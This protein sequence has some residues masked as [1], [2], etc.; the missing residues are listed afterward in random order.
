MRL[1]FPLAALVVA[2]S[3]GLASVASAQAP[4]VG[5]G[6]CETFPFDQ[7]YSSTGF[8]AIDFD[9]GWLPGGSPLQIRAT[10][11]IGGASTVKLAGTGGVSY[12]P[13]V[14]ASFLGEDGGYVSVDYGIE[15][16][17]YFRFDILGVGWEGEIPI[18]YIP[19]DLR[20]AQT[21]PIDDLV[22]IGATPKPV[23]AADVSARVRVVSYD[24]GAFLAGLVSGGLA[25]DAQGM[26]AATY[27]SQ[28]IRVNQALTPITRESGVTTVYPAGGSDYG[29]SLDVVSH[30]EGT[31]QHVGT[32]HLFPSVFLSVLGQ[33]FSLDLADLPFNLVNTTANV[34]FPDVIH[35]L[36]LPDMRI[37]TVRVDFGEHVMG[38]SETKQLFVHNEGDA[39]LVLEI[40]SASSVFGL[41]QVGV[42]TVAPHTYLDLAPTFHALGP[43]SYAE[44]VQIRS[45]DPDLAMRSVTLVGSSRLPNVS[46]DGGVDAATDVDAGVDGGR[47]AYAPSAVGSCGCSVEGSS[48]DA[49]PGLL[50][51]FAFGLSVVARRARR[52]ASR[53]D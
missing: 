1:T 19:S 49:T 39:P 7:T 30:A 52:R 13:A 5:T 38:E 31:L 2:A 8:M 53:V 25:L 20:L 36:P 34:R 45:N 22:L 11:H 46:L 23:V 4:C 10:L 14:R 17:L 9:S 27:D 16:H 24:L 32:I 41:S 33:G 50:V 40:V 29:A 3:L 47:V 15:V 12:P 6:T 28:R 35:H 48:R 51:T 43:G 42:V 18:P 21:V 37:D 26:L 44:S